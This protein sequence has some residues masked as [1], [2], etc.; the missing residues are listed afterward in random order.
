MHRI[1][2]TCRS[3]AVLIL[4]ITS[5]LTPCTATGQSSGPTEWES[6][7]EAFEAADAENPPPE[8]AVLFVGSSSIRGWETVDEDFPAINVIN[9]GFGGSQF[10]DLNYYIDR[11]VLPYRP[12]TIVV[13]EGDNDLAAE[14][15]P[16]TVFEDYKTF[17]HRVHERLPDTRIA[18]IAIKPSLSRWNIANQM[19]EANRL[20][21]EYALWR[22][23]L[24]YIDVFSPMLGPN[25]RPRP[26]VFT[27]DGL[28]M[29]D[30]GYALW[31]E[32][33]RPYLT[34][35]NDSSGKSP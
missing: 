29:N 13:Y 15:S 25:G 32:I 10:S 2:A 1:V 26:E 33:V 20:I 14:K 6:A 30:A 7:I 22:E 17:V 16:E 21:R 11:I 8:G 9:R 3:I 24:E 18:F 35:E 27:D 5:V 4:I 12:R 28:H 34:A 23:N 31:T 19:R